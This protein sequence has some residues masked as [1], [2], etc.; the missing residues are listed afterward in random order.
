MDYKLVAAQYEEEFV[1]SVN[2]YIQFGYQLYGNAFVHPLSG[3][4]YQPMIMKG[5]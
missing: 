1:N 4:F 3:W 2:H 5:E